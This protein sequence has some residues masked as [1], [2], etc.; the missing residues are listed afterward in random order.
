V[1]GSGW[2]MVDGRK[3]LGDLRNELPL[4]NPGALR[5]LIERVG[6]AEVEGLQARVLHMLERCEASAVT[7]QPHG[8]NNAILACALDVCD[9]LGALHNRSLL[10][11]GRSSH[12]APQR[13]RRQLQR[14]L[15]SRP[16]PL[17]SPSRRTQRPKSP[18]PLRGR[19]DEASPERS[20]W[21]GERSYWFGCRPTSEKKD[22]F[23]VFL[24]FY[25]HEGGSD[26]RFVHAEL[27]RAL[28]C[29][30]FVDQRDASDLGLI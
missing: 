9:A 1:A 14:I 10:W 29:R 23:A 30:C 24:S 6:E 3:L 27:E 21:F 12:T 13:N 18:W 8:T 16:L 7:W 19:A 15:T 26:A 28:G 4:R 2:D 25:R 17:Q 5:E 20:Y 22:E 11:H